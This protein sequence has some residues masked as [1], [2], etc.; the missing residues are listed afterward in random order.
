MWYLALFKVWSER[1]WST[2]ERVNDSIW[3]QGWGKGSRK[4]KGLTLELDLKLRL[5]CSIRCRRAGECNSCKGD[6]MYKGTEACMKELD[7]NLGMTVWRVV[8]GEVAG[9]GAWKGSRRAVVKDF[10]GDTENRLSLCFIRWLLQ[11][12]T[13]VHSFRTQ[14]VTKTKARLV[15][16]PSASVI[17]HALQCWAE[18]PL[19]DSQNCRL[20]GTFQFTLSSSFVL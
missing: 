10:V 1:P 3:A 5:L 4:L 15:W 11:V 7:E 20:A 9:M 16:G 2:D 8:C 19:P 14:A 12:G 13:D 18:G 6:N 17:Y